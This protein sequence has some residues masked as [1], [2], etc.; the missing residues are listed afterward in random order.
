MPFRKY[1]I[2]IAVATVV[3]LFSFI[4]IITKVDPTNTNVLG[5]ILFY[6]SLFFTLIGLLSLFMIAIRWIFI[7]NLALFTNITRSFRQSVLFS[8]TIVSFLLLKSVNLLGWWNMILIVGTVT[9]VELF[10]ASRK[11]KG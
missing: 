11:I 4:F 5:F 8:I 3:S 1:I 2:L 9:G 6:T 7:K 10:S